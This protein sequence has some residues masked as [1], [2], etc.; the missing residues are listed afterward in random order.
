[1][2]DV[3]DS[4]RAEIDIAWAENLVADLQNCPTK[5]ATPIVDEWLA[6]NVTSGPVV[7]LYDIQ[8][9]AKFWADIATQTELRVYL[10]AILRGLQDRSFGQSS[11]KR[12]FISLWEGFSE[13]DRFAFLS[14][15]DPNGQFQRQGRAL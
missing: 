6:S 10:G 5:Y 9:D 4:K 3:L 8:S 1:M 13:A 2:M 12:I 7:S 11:R 14:R 15:V